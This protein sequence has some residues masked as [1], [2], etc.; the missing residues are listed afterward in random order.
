MQA[1]C[2]MHVENLLK[3]PKYWA[4]PGKKTN[5]GGW[6]YEI[7]RGIEETNGISRD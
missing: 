7:S 5:M 4:T 6:G 3:G 2:H 1:F